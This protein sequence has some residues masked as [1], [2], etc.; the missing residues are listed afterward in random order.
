MEHPLRTK[1]SNR[2]PITMPCT[3]QIGDS[4]FDLE[5]VVE[6]ER[7][8]DGVA[9]HTVLVDGAALSLSDNQLASIADEIETLF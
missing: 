2:I 5:A 7:T 4:S 1:V 8:S 3:F 9:V 6:Y